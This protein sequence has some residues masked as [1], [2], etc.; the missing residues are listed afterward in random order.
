[1]SGN[2]RD[3][4]SRKY[5]KILRRNQTITESILWQRLRANRLENFHICRQHVIEP[6]I[7]DFCARSL[8]VV[9]ELKR[10]FNGEDTY[11]DLERKTY[12]ESKGYQ[13]ISFWDYEVLENVEK[14]LE[15]IKKALGV[16]K[17][18]RLR[19]MMC[20][21]IRRC[22]KSNGSLSNK[23]IEEFI[24]NIS[25]NIDAVDYDDLDGFL[26]DID[27]ALWEVKDVISLV[28]V[29]TLSDP[30]WKVEVCGVIADNVN[31]ISEVVQSIKDVWALVTYDYFGS[32]N[33]VFYQEALVF[34]FITVASDEKYYVSGAIILQGAHCQELIFEHQRKLGKTNNL[35]PSICKEDK[36]FRVIG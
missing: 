25:R 11:S 15:K 5:A 9:I 13:V 31:T 27:Y 19:K 28:K 16:R 18:E 6:Y 24:N 32:A 36:E 30:K 33:F 2:F 4:N 8:K 1:L 7:V 21:K 23:L 20:S 14:V 17:E 3:P 10:D 22:Y 26:M 12:L 34:R 35:L 29:N